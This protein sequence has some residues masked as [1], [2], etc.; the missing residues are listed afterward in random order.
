[1]HLILFFFR[2]GEL[3]AQ[4]NRY[5]QFVS[6]SQGHNFPEI[7][8]ILSEIFTKI[9]SAYRWQ[10]RFVYLSSDSYTEYKSHG[11]NH[12]LPLPTVCRC[13]FI[14]CTFSICSA[15]RIKQKEREK[16]KERYVR[17]KLR[18]QTIHIRNNY[19]EL[20]IA[21]RGDWA[22]FLC[23]CVFT[24]GMFYFSRLFGCCLMNVT[25]AMVVLHKILLHIYS[26]Q[27]VCKVSFKFLLSLGITHIVR[28]TE[29]KT[30][31]H[32]SILN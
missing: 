5:I 28:L 22:N 29:P 4:Q 31:E 14:A 18:A 10:W 26:M 13:L 3:A 32:R 15:K 24:V 20:K 27:C 1:M 30:N 16:A 17:Y 21:R 9:G 11:F 19:M 6:C 23:K 12:S 2:F 7:I 25:L 8:I